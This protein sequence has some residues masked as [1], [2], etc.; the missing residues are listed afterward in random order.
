VRVHIVTPANRALYAQELEQMHRLRHEIFVEELGWSA[1]RS[2]DRK[3]RDEF[4][5]GAAVYLLAMEDSVVHGSLRLLPT[6][7]RCMISERFAEWAGE[8]PVAA[9]GTAWEWT[10]W[11]PGT[12]KRARALIKARGALITAAVEFARSRGVETYYTFCET[13]FL[14]QLMELGWAPQPL[15]LP[16]GYDEG[17]AIAVRWSVTPDQLGKARAQFRIKGP[18]SFE[19]PAFEGSTLSASQIEQLLFPAPA[20]RLAPIV[21]GAPPM[22]AD[23]ANIAAQ[24][25]A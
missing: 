5:D 10:R 15:G 24:G 3:E 13:K 23:L 12:A 16:R 9:E 19:A 18:V 21:M 20:P 6:W 2:P 22:D 4:D 11:C 8:S 1:L 7:K 25:R 14:P 17:Q